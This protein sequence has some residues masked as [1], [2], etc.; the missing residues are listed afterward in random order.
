[1]SLTVSF[2]RRILKTMSVLD[3]YCL[4]GSYEPHMAT[5]IPLYLKQLKMQLFSTPDTF[6]ESPVSL[7]PHE[8]R[9]HHTGQH[10]YRTIPSTQNVVL[11]GTALHAFQ[12]LDY[13]D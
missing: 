6:K 1:M 4:H 7:E 9:G 13:L 3:V 5:S 11:D 8:A 2:L 10:R 12:T